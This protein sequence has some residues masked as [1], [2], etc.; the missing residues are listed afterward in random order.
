MRNFQLF[1]PP[2]QQSPSGRNKDCSALLQ[3]PGCGGTS[4]LL[5]PVDD[6]LLH[7]AIQ[8]AAKENERRRERQQTH[9]QA[10]DGELPVLEAAAA[11][12]GGEDTRDA[13]V[14]S[15]LGSPDSASDISMDRL[16]LDNDTGQGQLP[17]HVAEV[18]ANGAIIV[19]TSL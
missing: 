19:T 6:S 11:V 1:F 7:F 3:P 17:S 2:S 16:G 8:Q 12:D 10:A 13:S 14:R 4:A 5:V 9:T 15:R 18:G